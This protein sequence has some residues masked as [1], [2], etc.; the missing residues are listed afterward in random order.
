MARVTIGA[1][2]LTAPLPPA[3]VSVGVADEANLITIGWTGILASTPPSTYV[4][5]RKCRHSHGL[6]SRHGEFVIHLCASAMAAEVDFC[7]IYTGAKVNKWDKLGLTKTP[8]AHVDVPTVME[9]PVAIECRVREVVE[10]GSHDVFVADILG[11]T[12]REELL[13][14]KG[15]LHLERG[16]LLAYMHGEYYKVGERVGRFGFSATKPERGGVKGNIG[17]NATAE[18]KVPTETASEKANEGKGAPTLTRAQKK[19]GY[20]KGRVVPSR[21]APKNKGK[22]RAKK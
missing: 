11:V 14:E 4:S 12:V 5:I 3:L 10:M 18:K 8:S 13:D 17:K 1:G 15:K 19:T 9:A 2:T 21:P 22:G 16:D 20:P 6:L 7:G